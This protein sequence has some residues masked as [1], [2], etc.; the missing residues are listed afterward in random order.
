MGTGLCGNAY[1]SGLH[2]DWKRSD[3]MSDKKISIKEKKHETVRAMCEGAIAI[4]LSVVLSYLEIDIGAQGGSISFTMIP[5]IVFVLR[6]GVAL[7]FSATFA[8]GLI[9]FM[10]GGEIIAWQSIVFD[11]LLAYGVLG[12]AF[13]ARYIKGNNAVKAIVGTLAACVLRFGVHYLSGVT[14]Y[15]EWMPEEFLGM[16]MTSVSLYS[17]LYNGIYMLPSSIAALILVPVLF[18]VIQKV[19]PVRS[20]RA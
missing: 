17:L 6:R 2:S 1:R 5:L 18:G 10:L 19:L 13:L 4:A 3:D 8:F 11:Y 12:V 16:T 9:K 7:G 14:I 20:D 15:A